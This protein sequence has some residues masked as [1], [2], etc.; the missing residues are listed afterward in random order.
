MLSED[1]GSWTTFSRTKGRRIF[2][3][4]LI[5]GYPPSCLPCGA[6]SSP[7]S[8]IYWTCSSRS[9]KFLC[10]V[11]FVQVRIKSF[12]VEYMVSWGGMPS[13]I[14]GAVQ[15]RHIGISLTDYFTGLQHLFGY[16][17]WVNL[18]WSLGSPYHLGMIK[19]VVHALFHGVSPL[20]ELVFWADRYLS[21]NGTRLEES[22]SH[23]VHGIVY[24]IR[25]FDVRVVLLICGGWNISKCRQRQN[26]HLSLCLNKRCSISSLSF[27]S[28]LQKFRKK[29]SVCGWISRWLLVC[30]LT[31]VT[32]IWKSMFT[33]SGNVLVIHC[34][35]NF[36]NVCPPLV[37]HC[38][39]REDPLVN[40]VLQLRLMRLLF[41]LA[42]HQ[43][44]IED[45]LQAIVV[46]CKWAPI[47]H[48]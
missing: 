38:L 9:Y 33:D 11:E 19:I 8:L 3:L 48:L 26:I 15:W 30:H 29:S 32:I 25:D 1:I 14:S 7:S 2:K 46:I 6:Q 42:H 37:L 43:W 24:V 20:S 28:L 41:V 27:L 44:V 10:E 35:D 47:R 23:Q 21:S 40:K 31:H 17:F 18:T 39:G 45:L 13:V 4:D 34:R 12:W 5:K 22:V 16:L 36:I